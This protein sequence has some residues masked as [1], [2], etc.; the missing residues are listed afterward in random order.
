VSIYYILRE[1]E[2]EGETEKHTSSDLNTELIGGVNEI[3]I[4]EVI[5]PAIVVVSEDTH[6]LYLCRVSKTKERDGGGK[7]ERTRGKEERRESEGEGGRPS[8]RYCR[9]RYC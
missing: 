6:C 4:D 5:S 3:A 2:E 9:R 7:G 1:K 8:N